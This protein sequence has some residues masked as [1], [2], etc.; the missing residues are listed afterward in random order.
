MS[1]IIWSNQAKSE[2]KAIIS[3]Y[4]EVA[5]KNVADKIKKGILEAPKHAIDFNKIGTIDEDLHF[6][7]GEFRYLKYSHFKIIYTLVKEGVLITDVF[8]TRQNPIK[9]IR[10]KK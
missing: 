7:Q 6:L 10:E 1:K 2:L 8:D 3:Y 4:R 5:P 9:K